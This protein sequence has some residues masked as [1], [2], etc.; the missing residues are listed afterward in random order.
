M[1]NKAQRHQIK[2]MALQP[3]KMMSNNDR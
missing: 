1:E 2:E 3:Q